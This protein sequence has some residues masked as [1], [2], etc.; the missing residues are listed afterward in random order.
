MTTPEQI[1]FIPTSELHFDPENPRFYRLNDPSS[2]E[3]VIEEMLDDE[4]V[5]E[6]MLSIGQKGYFEGEPLLTV[7]DENGKLIVVEGNRRLA[8]TKLLNEEIN[9]PNRRTASIKLIRKEVQE[10]PPSAL[11][12]IVYPTRREVLR[13]LGYRHITGIKEWDSLSKARYLAQLRDEFY[14]DLERQ[15]QLKAL[16]NDI[17]SKP[18]YVGKLLTALSLYQRAED[19]KFFSLPIRA[20]DVEFSLLTTALYYKQIYTW[21][22]LESATDITMSNLQVDNLESIFSWMFAKDQQGRTILGESR[23]LKELACIVESGDAITVLKET[24]RLSE[25]F[26]YTDGPQAALQTAMGQAEE[27]LRVIWN[28]LQKTRP[29][30]EAHADT[31]GMLFERIRDVRKYIREKLDEE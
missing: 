20:E 27:R 5:Q 18:D 8:A 2:V 12:C 31:A 23:N 10:K 16:A 13:Y 28:M 14:P 3:A 11:P 4:G 15:V 6:L 24:G 7:A 22:G 19:S 21:L 9:P 30:S 17:G 29:F 25:A 1:K 26:L